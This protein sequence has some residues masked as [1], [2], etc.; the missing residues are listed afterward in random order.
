MA[1]FA[2]SRILHGVV[3]AVLPGTAWKAV[4]LSWI[5][6]VGALRAR[7]LAHSARVR[8]V[9]GCCGVLSWRSRAHQPLG[10]VHRYPRLRAVVTGFARACRPC[11]AELLAV[12][13]GWTS[14]AVRRLRL[15]SRRIVSARQTIGRFLGSW[16][17]VTS[18]GAYSAALCV[19]I[20][21][22]SRESSL[23]A[24][25]TSVAEAVRLSESF[26][27]AVP[28]TPAECAVVGSPQPFAVAEGASPARN[29]DHCRL[30]TIVSSRTFEWYP[31]LLW[32]ESSSRAGAAVGGRSASDY[33]T[34]PA[35]RARP[36]CTVARPLGAVVTTPALVRFV[37]GG[38]R[39]G[40]VVAGGR[41]Q[42]HRGVWRSV[43]WLPLAWVTSVGVRVRAPV[44][45]RARIHASR[46]VMVRFLGGAGEA[47]VA[48]GA[49]LTAYLRCRRGR[50]VAVVVVW[51]RCAARV[52][53]SVVGVAACATRCRINRA[54]TRAFP[55]SWAQLAP[56]SL[57]V[58]VR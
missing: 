7:C 45:R 36:R 8:V 46:M 55:S 28:A 51:A 30:W 31:R 29:R 44:A 38:A 11:A 6:V 15:A 39:Q 56:R 21:W 9:S 34:E 17:A 54:G 43:E 27:G 49:L 2:W 16:W 1:G 25:V 52:T 5:W 37:T 57:R 26:L 40:S 14:D 32:A 18:S 12:L 19:R 53:M 24:V 35:W 50:A 41:R 13:A 20:P 58:C 22:Q 47:D 23:S 10:A 3:R 48:I 42:A 33:V 4:R